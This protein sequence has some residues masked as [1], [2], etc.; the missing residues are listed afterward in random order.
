MLSPIIA[1]LAAI[2]TA[3]GVNVASLPPKKELNKFEQAVLEQV[4]GFD[5]QF[6]QELGCWDLQEIGIPFESCTTPTSKISSQTEQMRAYNLYLNYW[7]PRLA[8]TLKA[9]FNAKNKCEAQVLM[10]QALRNELNLEQKDWGEYWY[11]PGVCKP[12]PKDESEKMHALIELLEDGDSFD[13]IARELTKRYKANHPEFK[14]YFPEPVEL[15]P[16]A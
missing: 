14:D 3:A 9:G 10:T 5:E 1:A 11:I 7:V 6:P 12:L 15:Q 16:V 8:N 2:A 13:G 4:P